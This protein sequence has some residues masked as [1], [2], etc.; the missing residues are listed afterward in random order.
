[1]EAFTIP[2]VVGGALVA[3]LI[4][5][6][7]LV[8][9]WKPRARRRRRGPATPAHW[10]PF[11]AERLPLLRSLEDGEWNGLLELVRQFLQE[12]RFEGSHGLEVTDEMKLIVAA[13]ACLLILNLGAG[14]YPGL[15]AVVLY[16]ATFV[17]RLTDLD[18]G[19]HGGPIPTPEPLLGQHLHG[20]VVLSWDSIERGSASLGGG[21]VVLHE[22]AHELD[23][24]DGYV[25]GTPLLEAPS[26][27]R[28][29]ARVLQARFE[30]LRRTTAAGEPD[31]LS[32]YGA[33]NRAEF[34]AVA[35]EVFFERPGEMS[36]RYPDLY[37]ELRGF[38]RQDPVA[39]LA[40]PA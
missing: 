20:V 11:L 9:R 35:T 36:R 21:N 28:V 38:Y 5:G 15:R 23:R 32:A 1:M 4:L 13:Q 26:S 12:K 24:E 16:P 18:P 3:C 8:R 2:G 27:T 37:A 7:A 10:R 29:W 40:T 30:E 19:L 6:W 22:F 17:P 33:T 25:D 31:V 34:F 14:C 39:R